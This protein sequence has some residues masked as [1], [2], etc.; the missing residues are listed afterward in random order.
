MYQ[1]LLFFFLPLHFI[2]PLTRPPTLH[3]LSLTLSQFEQRFLP[4]ISLPMNNTPWCYKTLYLKQCVSDVS[5]IKKN[6]FKQ[7]Y[8]YVNDLKTLEK[9]RAKQKPNQRVEKITTF[10]FKWE[11]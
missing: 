4:F 10:V 6:Q 8:F 11:T 3:P 2:L 9:C 5:S 1:K 7:N